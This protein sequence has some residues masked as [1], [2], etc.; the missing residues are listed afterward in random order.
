MKYVIVM[1]MTVF[2]ISCY[3][4]EASSKDCGIDQVYNEVA[5]SCV[6]DMCKYN[7]DPE[8]CFQ[9]CYVGDSLSFGDKSEEGE[10]FGFQIVRCAHADGEGYRD[11]KFDRN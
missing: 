5:K 2:M 3:E 8:E 10:G 1:L 9:G 7:S 6:L 11:P 4:E